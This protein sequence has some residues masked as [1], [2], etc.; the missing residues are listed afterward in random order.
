MKHCVNFS[1]VN[2]VLMRAS[3]LTRKNM[4]TVSC[5]TRVYRVCENSGVRELGRRC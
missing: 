4:L 3:Q 5:D 2:P 1:Y